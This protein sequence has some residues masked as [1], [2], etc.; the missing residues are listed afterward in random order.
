MLKTTR[1]TKKIHSQ[2]VA[3]IFIIVDSLILVPL[4]PVMIISIPSLLLLGVFALSWLFS[5]EFYFGIILFAFGA[6]LIAFIG[7]G[8]KLMFGYFKHYKNHLTRKEVDR[9]WAKT[10]I[11][12]SILFFPSFYFKLQCWFNEKCV[13][14]SSSGE[15]YFLF[16]DSTLSSILILWWFLAIFLSFSALASIDDFTA[17]HHLPQ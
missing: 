7:F 11:Y 16:G 10:I 12:N 5:R 17:S 6:L 8:M 3:L 1:L 15:L 2:D 13:F 9:L 4:I 14:D